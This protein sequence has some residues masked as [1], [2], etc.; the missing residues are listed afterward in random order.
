MKPLVILAVLFATSTATAQTV[1]QA[2]LQQATPAQPAPQQPLILDPKSWGQDESATAPA[3][4][5]A[6]GSPSSRQPS[7]G[8]TLTPSIGSQPAPDSMPPD[9][10]QEYVPTLRFKVPL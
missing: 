6:P 7:T 2:P 3:S 1:R 9:R 5:F 4:S 10:R 8:P